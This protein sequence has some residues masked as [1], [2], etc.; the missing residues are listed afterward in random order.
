MDSF[1]SA[2]LNLTP[3]FL[4]QTY[5]V[6]IFRIWH[7]SISMLI[8]EFQFFVVGVGALRGSQTQHVQ[9]STRAK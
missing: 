2:G 9:K 1:L 8:S 3:I 4:H 5:N 7:D 6:G